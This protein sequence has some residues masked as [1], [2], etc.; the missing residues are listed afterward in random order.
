MHI[1]KSAKIETE[2][3]AKLSGTAE[4]RSM[5]PERKGAGDLSDAEER[6]GIGKS[7]VRRVE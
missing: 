3:L 6:S 5:A 2:R 7:R 1:G 4:A